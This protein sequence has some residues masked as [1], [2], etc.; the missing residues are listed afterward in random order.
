MIASALSVAFG[1]SSPAASAAERE[2]AK[3]VGSRRASIVYINDV[4]AQL[5][6]HPELFWSGAEEEYVRDAG[7]LSRIATVFNRLRAERPGEL[8]FVDG[9]DTIQGSGPAA[10]TEGKVVVDPMNAL[11]LDVAIPGN[12]SIAYGPS[13]WKTRAQEFTYEVVAANMRDGQSGEL[14]FEPYTIR[15]INGIRFGIIGFTEPDI[16]TRQPPHLSEGLAFQA[17]EV[18]PPLVSEL[19]EEHRV[20][21][22]VLATHI[23]LPKAIGLA[24][25][26]DGI[27]I[28]LSAD[29]HERTYEPIVRGD[30]WIVEAGA[31]GSFV[32]LLD[33]RIDEQGEIVD[34]AWRLIELRPELYPED[35]EMKRSVDASLAP[36]RERMNRVIGHTDIWLARY[37]VLNTS[38]DNVIADAIREETGADIGLSNG[39]RFAPPTAPGPITEA[40]LWTWLPLR[41]ELKT[42]QASGAQLHKYWEKELENSLSK[43]PQKL[44]GGWLPRVSGLTVDFRMH[45]A[46]GE[47]LERLRIGGEPVDE[48]QMYTLAAGNRQ[49][50]PEDYIHRV[51][52]CQLTQLQEINTHDAVENYLRRHSPIRADRELSVRCL[53]SPGVLR[54]QILNSL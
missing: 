30:T 2:D 54:S 46:A 50:A 36:H 42:G 47:R 40:D 15:T 16:P 48:H 41:L 11:G 51:S 28:I 53:D 49:G 35:P 19:R 5:E 45:A 12:W 1:S 10:W 7:G 3:A 17:E 22:V 6:P 32:G 21:V 18:L 39:F 52:G 44:F 27:D 31:F 24:E 20:D 8:L 4:H 33:L 26:I 9:G 43:D 13:P 23:G 38:L 37:E 34:R 29:T 14:L 25:T